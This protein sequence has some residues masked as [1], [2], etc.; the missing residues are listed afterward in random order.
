V[1]GVSDLRGKKI[2]FSQGQAQ[3]LVVL[4][5][6]KEQGLTAKD[7][8]LVTLTSNQFLVALQ[9]KQ[10]DVA[11][12]SEPVTTKYLSQYAKDGAKAIPVTAVDLL[13]IL[14]SPTEVLA[15]ARKAAAIRAFIPFWAR[16]LVWAYENPDPWIDAYYVKDQT[17]TASDGKR[18]VAALD[19]P[20]FP[21][22]W[23]HARASPPVF[24]GSASRLTLTG[25][26]GGS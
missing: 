3:G 17:V 9:S 12:L 2:G 10:I 21:R 19:K 7:V 20:V 26:D 6:L 24:T 25:G 18:I 23:D 22:N 14:W 11:P 5:V 13:S 1:A 16:S 15:D 4:R 8:H